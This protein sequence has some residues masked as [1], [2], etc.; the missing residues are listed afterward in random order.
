MPCVVV[1][2]TRS[3]LVARATTLAPFST[4]AEPDTTICVEGARTLPPLP[5]RAAS[6]TA[7]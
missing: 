6:A 1:A 4:W 5:A 2:S 3:L 7:P